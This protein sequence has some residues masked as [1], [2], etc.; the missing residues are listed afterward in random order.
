MNSKTKKTDS[1]VFAK[2]AHKANL[3]WGIHK[4]NVVDTREWF[5]LTVRE[6]KAKSSL[7]RTLSQ[8]APSL[9]SA[10]YLHDEWLKTAKPYHPCNK[11]WTLL[12]LD[13]RFKDEI[14]LSFIKLSQIV[15]E[16]EARVGIVSTLTK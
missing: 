2:M 14:Y 12:T 6:Q 15:M 3:M 5:E 11:E 7:M 13:E 8:V 16:R 10:K 4:N 9:L 1:S